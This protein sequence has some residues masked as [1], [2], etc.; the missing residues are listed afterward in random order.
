[1]LDE[2]G[3][4]LP[5]WSVGSGSACWYISVYTMWYTNS[6]ISTPGLSRSRGGG[7]GSSDCVMTWRGCSTWEGDW[8][9]ALTHIFLSQVLLSL[10]WK[11]ESPRF[12][13]RL[14]ISI[15]ENYKI[16]PLPTSPFPTPASLGTSTSQP[17][18]WAGLAGQNSRALCF[19]IIHMSVYSSWP[20]YTR[21]TR[22]RMLWDQGLSHLSIPCRTLQCL[23]YFRYSVFADW[24]SF[25][26]WNGSTTSL[27]LLTLLNYSILGRWKRCALSRN[28]R[29]PG[30]VLKPGHSV[31]KERSKAGAEADGV[32]PCSLCTGCVSAHGAPATWPFSI[33][34]T[35]SSTK[36]P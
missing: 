5:K 8:L 1:M 15:G 13:Q 29:G 31:L 23:A 4:H 25:S 28:S 10:T 11:D 17:D 19:I 16:P 32:G 30:G 36:L 24:R 14:F 35:S 18:C 12:L 6:L 2:R 22:L 20:E 21:Y 7:R 3:Q 27:G 9:C 26:E 33:S 34:R